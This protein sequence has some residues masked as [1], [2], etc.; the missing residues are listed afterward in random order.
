MLV[1]EGQRD[2]CLAVLDKLS[3][4]AISRPFSQPVDPIRDNMPNYFALVQRPMDLGTVRQKLLANEYPSVSAWRDDVELIWANSL[5]VNPKASLPGTVTVEL[6]GLFRRLTQHFTDNP[7][8]D[9]LAGLN[10]LR[11]ELS[12]VQRTAKREP[13]KQPGGK[14]GGEKTKHV[15]KASASRP[16]IPKLSPLL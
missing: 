4:R 6:Q 2:R 16:D 1:T 15:K 7:D 9:W 3:S 8:S 12:G 5:A 13:S 14:A 11:D 10:S